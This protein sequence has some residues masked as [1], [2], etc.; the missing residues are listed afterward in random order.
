MR[1]A[2]ISDTHDRL[3]MI[4]LAVKKMQEKDVEM[5]I[6]CGDFVAPFSIPPFEQLNVPFIAVYGNNDGEKKGLTEKISK[7]GGIVCYPPLVR[8]VNNIKFLICHEPIPEES[9][10][11]YFSDVK[12]YVF[13]HTHEV[14]EKEIEG[15]KVI[16]P[17]EACG[18]LTGNASFAILDIQTGKVEFITL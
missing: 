5:I 16:N 4:H 13:G 14:V 10:K 9:L 12:Y 7:I 2:I 11:R 3:D 15:I 17:G 1:L 18:W 6:H 8:E